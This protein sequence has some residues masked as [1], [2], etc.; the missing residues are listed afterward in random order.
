M[1]EKQKKDEKIP[2][3]AALKRLAA[4]S[5]SV[6]VAVTSAN[7]GLAAPVLAEENQSIYQKYQ[8][9]QAQRRKRENW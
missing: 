9:P 1:H 5:L 8:A 6:I 7:L 3:G 2:A 4:G